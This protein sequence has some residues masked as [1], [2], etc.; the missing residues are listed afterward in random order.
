[1]KPLIKTLTVCII[2]S[3]ANAAEV[4]SEPK[5]VCQDYSWDDILEMVQPYLDDTLYVAL[6]MQGQS[7]NY[8]VSAAASQAMDESLP[9]KIKRTLQ[10]IIKENC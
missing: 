8:N 3:F 2:T 1:M 10:A 4:F 6:V 7:S 5:I 9:K